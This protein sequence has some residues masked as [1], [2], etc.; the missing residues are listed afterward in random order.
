MT[1][2]VPMDPRLRA[3][4]VAVAGSGA[5]LAVGALLTFGGSTA[6]SVAV[7]GGLA[8]ANLWALARIIGALLPSDGAAAAAQSR[9]GWSLVVGL[10]M[11]GL[12]LGAWLLMRHGWVAPLPLVV[13]FG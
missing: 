13:G 10:K 8:A 5:A 11:I 9:A 7:G 1:P 12:V 4:L 2:A 3:C 6:L